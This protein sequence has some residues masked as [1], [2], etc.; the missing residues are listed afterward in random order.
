MS[1]LLGTVL[2]HRPPRHCPGRFSVRTCSGRPRRGPLSL[3][4]VALPSSRLP[5]RPERP[6]R[7]RF[8][9]SVT[10]SPLQSPSRGKGHPVVKPSGRFSFRFYRVLQRNENIDSS[11]VHSVSSPGF[12]CSAGRQK[13]TRSRRCVCALPPHAR[14]RHRVPRGRAVSSAPGLAASEPAGLSRAA[15]KNA[16]P[17]TL[18]NVPT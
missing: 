16:V 5:R 3:P 7:L 14:R 10:T 6:R 2:C 15:E 18:L 13:H 1:C 9:P 4:S 11:L 12:Q 8:L 17:M